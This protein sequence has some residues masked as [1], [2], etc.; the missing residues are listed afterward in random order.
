MCVC[1]RGMSDADVAWSVGTVTRACRGS[2]SPGYTTPGCR[3]TPASASC[4]WSTVRNTDGKVD[5]NETE[6]NQP[7]NPP[8]CW[9]PDS[10][11]SGPV[12]SRAR[13]TG[14]SARCSN[15]DQSRVKNGKCPTRLCQR[16]NSHSG[17]SGSY[18]WW[19]EFYD[20]P[21]TAAPSS[22]RSW[23]PARTTGPVSG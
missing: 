12:W 7:T 6:I 16:H 17:W 11:C 19:R 21:G 8:T 3:R 14:S 20:H 13:R 1:V 10:P 15:A 18:T 2:D 4:T 9:E 22:G 5:G 23:S